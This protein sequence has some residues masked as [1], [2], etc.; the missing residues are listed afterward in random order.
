TYGLAKV[1]FKSDLTQ[2][3]PITIITPDGRTLY[4]RPTFLVLENRVT[5]ESVILGTVTNR[6]GQ[7]V[8]PD[9]VVWTNA[10]DTGP[11]I[12]LEYRYLPKGAGLEQDVVLLES[13]ALPA[14]WTNSDVDLEFWTEWIDSS[15]SDAETSSVTLRAESDDLP[16]VQAD[17]QQI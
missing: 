4:A 11:N 15:P 17:D 8:L 14:G 3:K 6:I 2:D 13:P 10:L 16:P 5:G 12:S 9:S 7:V 1:L